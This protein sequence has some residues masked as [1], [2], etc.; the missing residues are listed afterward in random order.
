[1]LAGG[2]VIAAPSM[3]PTAAAAGALYVSAENAQFDNL[4]GGPMVVEVIVK[5][6][7]RSRTDI[8]SGEPTVLVDNQRLRMAQGLDGNWYGYFADD[9]DVTTVQALTTSSANY[10]LHFGTDDE[11]YIGT[12]VNLTVYSKDT[13]RAIATS[14]VNA[15]G[16]TIGG[17]GVIDNPPALSN[18][19]STLGASEACDA[20]GQIG[21][22]STDWPFLQTFD[23]SQEDF[24][25]IYEQAGTNEV[26]TLEHNNNDLDDYASLTLDRSQAT[27]DAQVML[28]IVDQ[29]LNIDPTDED[30][31]IF[32]VAHNG[33]S[34]G[35]GVAFTNGTIN[36]EYIATGTNNYTAATDGFA[37]D[38]NGKL[39]IDMNAAGAD[40]NV[41]EKDATA[42]DTVVSYTALF[43]YL[44]F[45][46]DAD[47]TGTFS[48]VDDVDDAN[49][50]VKSLAKRGTTATFD[51]NDSAQS[52]TVANDFGTID[53]DES[54]VGDE[55]NS[56]E[57][58]VVTLTDQD[59]NKN[60]LSDEDMTLR[61][62]N[63][64]IPA[65]IIGSPITLHDDSMIGVV[66]DTGNMTVSAFNK[67]GTI[68]DANTVSGSTNAN[69][70]VTFN[71]TTVA[72]YRTAATAADFIFV[73]YN[74]TQVVEVVGGVSLAFD[75]GSPLL[76]EEDT[77]G[78]AGLLRLDNTIAAAGT[79]AQEA[80][81]LLLNFT[82][83]TGGLD[84]AVGETLF[85]DI[86]T[87]GDKTGYDRQNNAIYRLLLEETGDNTG[88]FIGDVEY[89][90]LNQINYD[91][92]TTYSTLDTLSD[93]ISIIVHED[94]TD[95]DAPR[96][97]YLDLGADGVST[98]IADQVAAPSHSGVV[99]F[100][101][102]N[103]K[104]ADTVVVTLDDQ[105]LNTDS[106]LVDVYITSTSD[107]VGEN[108]SDATSYVLDITFNDVLWQSG[109]DAVSSTYAGSPDDGLEAS[110]FTLVETG[111]ATGLFTGSF[112]VPSTYYDSAR[113]STTAK[114][115]TTTGTD[116]EVNY[117][118][119]RDASGE[120]IEVGAG[121]S[122]NANTG[123]V[124]FDRTVYPVPWGNE[125][126][127]ER[128]ALHSSA[129]N[130][131]GGSTE[132]ALAQG[133]VVVHVRVSDADYDVSAFGEDTI[134]DTTVVLK[135]ERGSSSTTVA[136]FG[137][138]TFPILETSPT[139]G[140]FEYDQKIT[141]TDG[142]DDS[143][144]PAVFALGCVLQG[145]ILTVTYSDVKDAS[146]QAQ[147]VTDSATFD[148]RN[149]VLQSDKSVYLI[150]SDMILTLIEPDFDLDND[151]A[152][153]YTL[154]LIEWDSD[155]AETSMG[156]KGLSGA[157]AA[158][159]PEPSALRETGDSTGIF[160]VVI[161]IPDTLNSELLDRGEKIDL[162]YTDWGPAGADYVG[163][164]DEDIGLTVY[165]SNF[166][167]TI[168]LDQKVYTWT[169]KV[170]ITVVAP[171][172]NFDSNLVDEIG[173]TSND[174][175]KVSTRGNQ[176]DNYK[177]V[178][179]GADTGIFIGEVTLNGFTFDADGDGTNDITTI[180]GG[181][182]GDGP[183][184][185]KLATTDNDGLTVS[186]EFSEDE[187]VVGS[188]LIRW[189]IGEVQ[190]LEA[191]YPA[192]GTG[193]VRI[194]DAD[195]NLNPEAI[196]N[197]AV[198]AWSD[199]DAGGIDLTVTETNE[200]TGIFEGTVFFTTANDSSGHRLRVAEGDTVTA[201]YEDNTLPEPYTTADELDITA[202]TLIGTIVPPLERAPAANLR[203]VDAFG[204][205]LNSV[206]VDQ[207]VQIS[208]DLANGQD[209]E[210][211]FA[212]LVQIQD[213]DGVT[214]SLAWIT[215]SLSSG[216][217]FS[218]ALSWI[219][220]ESGSYTATAFVWESVDNPT[221]LSP[222]VS[223]T[224]SVQ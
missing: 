199:S 205:S 220:T 102:D 139:S 213:G 107:H 167:A 129:A 206:S 147:T 63:T 120:T 56:G 140:V 35:S 109:E 29:A 157:N 194:I 55:W 117:N 61:T 98:Q 91:V 20:C 17:D 92:A 212:Y 169:D 179:S 122:I 188:A 96:I 8:A 174:P 45:F 76:I 183:T 160:Q 6:P 131:D 191:S 34:T 26:V 101:N 142:P 24:D 54:S 186:F 130:L 136:T 204:N 60:T 116:I 161:E 41:L 19:N 66:G 200:A 185:G 104:T 132:N 16:T 203:T 12:G 37:F 90:M 223:T 202:T 15:A 94:L 168:E 215:G 214:V 182:S 39:L 151:G 13:Y 47:N 150:G 85:V 198:D 162:E 105:D 154:D 175:V 222:P 176:L 38:D 79:A 69:V 164:E 99:T 111:I 217:S 57:N 133:N 82:Q 48:N 195:M 123:S 18:Y 5:D 88:V 74:V 36:Y 22:L 216:Q 113:S 10:P 86:F 165:T 224:I 71:G 27:Q 25:V 141:F 1:M 80:G 103:Y 93:E 170:Y 49:L 32:K 207:Q 156:A 51:Y 187:T 173:N 97:N 149:G 108:A 72:Q 14:S 42:D 208:A 219:P 172:H 153:S 73:N 75:D 78:S 201:E 119:H 137:N 23:F 64:T 46:E 59:L 125:T 159:D 184:E 166:G 177:L 126:A 31:V 135:I 65:M 77:S 62:H 87:F 197:F 145:D 148:L 30:I 89:L 171:D 221:A 2:M 178:E 53:M 110:G 21:I 44:V 121:A 138:S 40:V 84:A 3:V 106:E 43:T 28:F 115:H 52:F 163:Q 193:V 127:G 181:S 67:I 58:L 70:T 81:V 11:P 189:N 180:T 118:D 128:F 158:F 218:P 100:D 144:C 7:N 155:A 83:T 192:S 134:A 112:Q 196:D 68:T 4:F 143:A 114:T 211:S 124:A 152:E 50:E 190:W 146:G 9:A 210:Q 209:R 95:E 33:S